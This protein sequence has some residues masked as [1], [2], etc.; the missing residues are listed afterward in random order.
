MSRIACTQIFLNNANF[1]KILNFRYPVRILDYSVQTSFANLPDVITL[2]LALTGISS[3]QAQYVDPLVADFL[4]DQFT[5][6][7]SGSAP[8][9]I[10]QPVDLETRRVVIGIAVGA[11]PFECFINLRFSYGDDIFVDL[12]AL[13][14]WGYE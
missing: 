2:G 7:I 12:N 6:V 1:S 10:F 4:D 14:E 3:S 9:P 13:N 5:H 8:N 11:N